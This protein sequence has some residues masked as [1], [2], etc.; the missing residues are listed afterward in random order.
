MDQLDPVAVHHTKTVGAAR[1]RAVHSVWGFK[2]P[3]QAGALGHL[4]KQRY[5][6]TRQPA[7]EGPG[8]AAFDGMQQG[9]GNDFICVLLDGSLT[10]TI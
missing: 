7:I 4:G 6:V 9:Q 8:P 2:E 5:G 1:N 10:V 3:G